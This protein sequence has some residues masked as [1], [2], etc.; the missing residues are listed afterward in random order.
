MK[1]HQLPLSLF[2]S[3][4]FSSIAGAEKVVGWALS[5]HLMQ[6]LEAN[7]DSRVLLSSERLSMPSSSFPFE[8]ISFGHQFI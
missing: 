6:N 1:S 5:H 2:L 8:Y 4:T 3:T 7:P